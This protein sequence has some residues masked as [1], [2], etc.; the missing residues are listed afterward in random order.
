[1]AYLAPASIAV[2][3]DAGMIAQI[4]DL[5]EILVGFYIASLAAVA[6]FK[7]PMLD[8]IMPGRPPTLREGFGNDAVDVVLT[9]RKYLSLMFGYLAYLG[10]VIY[11]FGMMTVLFAKSASILAGSYFLLTKIVFVLVYS[12]MVSNLFVTTFLGLHYL[13][14]RMHVSEPRL[15]PDDDLDQR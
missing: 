9:R 8:S 11:L 10:L 4:N 1:M 12:F 2:T 15:L 6:T 7:S 13:S 14:Y 5:L 3:G